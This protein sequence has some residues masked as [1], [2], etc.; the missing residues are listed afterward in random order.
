MSRTRSNVIRHLQLKG[1]G[2]GPVSEKRVKMLK[3]LILVVS[4][5]LAV[6]ACQAVGSEVSSAPDDLLD[7]RDVTLEY[8][9]LRYLV[10]FGPNMGWE[11]IQAEDQ[12]V[13]DWV[14]YQYSALPWVVT[15]GGSVPASDPSGY[16]VVVTNPMTGF[17]WE[18][19]VASDGL[20]EEGSEQVLAACDAACDYVTDRF[21]ELLSGDLE[22]T[23]RRAT[24]GG[25]VGSETYEYT[26]EDWELTVSYPV[27]APDA[28]MYH[29]ALENEATGFVWEGEMDPERHLTETGAYSRVLGADAG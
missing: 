21:P 12:Q 1:V 26:A 28:V 13:D 11:E 25:L 9:Q 20:V 27:V 17:S 3:H 2:L 19:R 7:A 10:G 29:V 14:E 16:D 5:M 22:W 8:L 6:T 4:L 23:G 18:G 15:I 24:P